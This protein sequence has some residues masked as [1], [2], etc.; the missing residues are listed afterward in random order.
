MDVFSFTNG[1]YRGIED[2]EVVLLNRVVYFYLLFPVIVVVASC[3]LTSPYGM[4]A[5]N[6]P[7]GR[8]PGKLGWVVMEAVS[9]LIYLL[10]FFV[11]SSTQSPQ[12]TIAGY[13]FLGLWLVHYIN[14]SFVSVW[15]SPYRSPIPVVACLCAIFFNTGNAYMNGRWVAV[16]GEYPDLY[17]TRPNFLLGTVLFLVGFLGNI[18]AE[19]VLM[20][21][22]R[23]YTPGKDKS[24]YRIPRGFLFEYVSCPHYFFEIL[25]W[26]GYAVATNSIPGVLFALCTAANLIPRAVQIHRWYQ[27]TF[28]DY[29]STRKA[30]IPMIL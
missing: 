21:L 10:C 18:R 13:F 2:P 5:N 26:S 11:P 22:R 17:L 15:R 25:E 9:P 19:N 20:N 1:T 16:F 28:K 24:K 23:N 14:R 7:F 12:P 29:P 3:V 6:V 27:T 4:L 8:V 30:V